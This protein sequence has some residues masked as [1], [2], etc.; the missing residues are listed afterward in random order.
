M[1]RL[2]LALLVLLPGAAL[3][4]PITG[5]DLAEIRTAIYRQLEASRAEE[6]R[7]TCAVDRPASVVFLE[8][9]ALGPDAVQQVKITDRQGRAWLAYYAMQRQRDGSW[10]TNGCRLVQPARTIPT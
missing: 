8:L 6:A 9:L 2:L 7:G 3:A 10:R 5:D 4:D 1:S